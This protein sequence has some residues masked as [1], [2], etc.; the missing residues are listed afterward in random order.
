MIVIINWLD[1]LISLKKNGRELIY[2]FSIWLGIEDFQIQKKVQDF[3]E[4][5]SDAKYEKGFFLAKLAKI[6]DFDAR[7]DY[8]KTRAT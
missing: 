7:V 3:P 1:K 5:D 6:N 8:I 2:L 4:M